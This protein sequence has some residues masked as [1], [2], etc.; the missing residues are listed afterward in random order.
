MNESIQQRNK[1]HVIGFILFTLAIILLAWFTH[2]RIADFESYHLSIAH[3]S[4]NST[5]EK[6]SAFVI[7]RKRLVRL[8]ANSNIDLIRRVSS[9]GNVNAAYIELTNRARQFFPESFA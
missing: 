7:E 6:V 4:A 8:F 1:G 3:I 9:E 2:K 5:A